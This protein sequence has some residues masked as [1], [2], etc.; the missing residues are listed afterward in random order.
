MTLKA[1]IARLEQQQQAQEDPGPGYVVL[2]WDEVPQPAREGVKAITWDDL[3]IAAGAKIYVTPEG[4][5][6]HGPDD[7]PAPA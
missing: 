5:D 2:N 7:W 4:S 6:F 1:R 3:D